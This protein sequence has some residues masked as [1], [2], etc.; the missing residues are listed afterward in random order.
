LVELL[1]KIIGKNAEQIPT[2]E[3]VSTLRAFMLASSA[4]GKI[5][6]ALLLQIKHRV[7]ELNLEELCLVSNLITHFDLNLEHYYELIEPYILHK[8]HSLTEGDLTNAIYGFHNKHLSRRFEILEVL[9]AT[10]INQADS[11]SLETLSNLS[12]FYATNRLGSDVLIKSL[13]NA[14]TNI[15]LSKV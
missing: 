9:E 14:A 15:E 8:I 3:L 5:Y 4:R 12:Y 1:D 11:L 6:E 2:G 10:L 13:I 7:G